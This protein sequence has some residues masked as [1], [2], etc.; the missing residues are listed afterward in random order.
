MLKRFANPAWA[1]LEYGWYPLLLFVTTPWFLQRLGVAEYGYWMLLTATT[2][3][4]GILTSGTGSATIKAVSAAGAG[5]QSQSGIAVR[6]ALAL[7]LLG[8]AL[9]AI[10][11]AASFVFAG[12]KLLPRMESAP[13]LHLTGIAAA[14]LL[15]IE[16]VDN[17][18]ASAIKGLSRFDLAARVEIAARTAQL[19]AAAAVLV[20]FPHL[21]GLYAALA[22]TAICR[23]VAKAF[24]AKR[25]L[26]LTTLA[27]TLSGHQG[28]LHFAKW[29][30]VLGAGGVLFGVADRFLIGGLL[31]A[32]ALAYYAI[33][34]QLAMQ[35]HAVA[36][37]GLSV[38]FPAISRDVADAQ[39]PRIRRK[40]VAACL[41]N[42]ALSSALAVGIWLASPWL[43]KIWVGPQASA[44]ALPVLPWLILAYWIL[45]L[46][47]VPYYVLLGLGKIRF[48]GSTVL[49]AGIAAAACAYLALIHFGA[50]AAPAGRMAYAVLSLGLA[51]PFVSYLLGRTNGLRLSA[52]TRADEVTP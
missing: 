11:V 52:A 17:V 42:L 35:V 25:L 49:L 6:N 38:I 28:L 47:V 9:L 41:S 10:A 12:N 29:G 33:A 7:A 39:T 37:A 18:F 40:I 45:A 30:W 43:L 2:G 19:A 34:S 51:A 36:A 31:G 14:A 22:A 46:N 3:L 50:L 23:L 21:G 13:L 27:P 44:S 24:L 26:G 32:S 1:V 16:Q 15:W 20:P 4:G 5:P 8:G 48:V